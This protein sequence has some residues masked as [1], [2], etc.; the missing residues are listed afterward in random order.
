LEQEGKRHC[1]GVVSVVGA[2]IKGAI[3][4]AA[5]V[6]ARPKGKIFSSQR[7]REHTAKAEE[8][9]SGEVEI[10]IFLRRR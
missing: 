3:L 1:S 9:C 8:P 4:A 5:L 7:G 6:R 10:A 2:G